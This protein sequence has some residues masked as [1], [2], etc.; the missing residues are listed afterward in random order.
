MRAQRGLCGKER[1][2]C[3]GRSKAGLP[4]RSRNAGLPRRSRSAAK[5]GHPRKLT[6][7]IS[8]GWERIQ[9]AVVAMSTTIASHGAETRADRDG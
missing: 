1:D 8:I 7:R 5:A 2:D 4:R 6:A 9:S 3:D